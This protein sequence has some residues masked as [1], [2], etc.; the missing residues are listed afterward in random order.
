MIRPVAES[1][2]DFARRHLYAGPDC[3]QIEGKSSF[4]YPNPGLLQQPDEML[5]QDT[6]AKTNWS[7][8]ICGTVCIFVLADYSVGVHALVGMDGCNLTTCV[9]VECPKL[10]R[11][12]SS[13]NRF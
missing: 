10:C 3:D 13:C 2:G 11:R 5:L 7:V 9:A 1:S 8:S 6:T 12:K 4:D